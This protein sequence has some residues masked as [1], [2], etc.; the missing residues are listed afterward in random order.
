D[1]Q[2]HLTKLKKQY[3]L[4]QLTD[5][6]AVDYL[7]YGQSDWQVGKVVS[8]TGISRGRQQDFNTAAVDNRLEIIYQLLSMAN[9]VRIR[10]K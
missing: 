2:L 1:T 3:Q 5:V 8:Q 7:T 4:E 9:N 10:F 6:P